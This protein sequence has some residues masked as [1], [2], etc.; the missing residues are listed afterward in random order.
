[1]ENKEKPKY[2]KKPLQPSTKKS[3]NS[4]VTM[5]FDVTLG[6]SI[7]KPLFGSQKNQTRRLTDHTEGI[8]LT[9]CLGLTMQ[10]LH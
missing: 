2:L 9:V 8:G 5:Y 10:A 7:T 4:L 6:Q 3:P 1:M